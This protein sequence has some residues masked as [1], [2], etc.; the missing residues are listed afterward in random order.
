MVTKA[1]AEKYKTLADLTGQEIGV[2]SGTTGEVT[3][4]G[5]APSALTVGS[6]VW[7]QAVSP[8]DGG[9]VTPVQMVTVF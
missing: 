7:F 1:N 3:V 5:R 8:V 9:D 6:T 4:T 2:Q